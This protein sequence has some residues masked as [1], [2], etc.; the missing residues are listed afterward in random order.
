MI[1]PV[2]SIRTIRG[3]NLEE[4]QLG[5]KMVFV[6]DVVGLDEPLTSATHIPSFPSYY[7]WAGLLAMPPMCMGIDADETKSRMEE[8]K[9]EQDE[10]NK[11]AAIEEAQYKHDAAILR[12]IGEDALDDL[13]NHMVA[14]W[15]PV[16][17]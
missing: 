12:P 11:Q 9:R 1:I 3:I 7:N 17:K 15:A 13:K 10:N 6:F 14:L 16:Y 2:N 5:A 4:H 8:W